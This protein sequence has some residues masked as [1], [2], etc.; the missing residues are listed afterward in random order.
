MSPLA[1]QLLS[2]FTSSV[3]VGAVGSKPLRPGQP[4]KTIRKGVV[5]SLQTIQANGNKVLAVDPRNPTRIE[6]VDRDE[7]VPDEDEEDDQRR[8]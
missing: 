3:S 1:E 2:E 4:L 5:Q 6:P 7:V 8:P